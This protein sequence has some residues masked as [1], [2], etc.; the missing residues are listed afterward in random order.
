MQALYAAAGPAAEPGG[1]D[2]WVLPASERSTHLD[3]FRSGEAASIPAGDAGDAG[4]HE[5][6]GIGIWL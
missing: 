4:E 3:V 2:R 5:A 1:A 6:L